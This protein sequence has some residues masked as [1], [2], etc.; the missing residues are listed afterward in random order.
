MTIWFLSDG[1]LGLPIAGKVA[2]ITAIALVILLITLLDIRIGKRHEASRSP[3]EYLAEN[4][5]DDSGS[6]PNRG[7]VP[8]RRKG[9]VVW[10]YALGD[11][12][13]DWRQKRIRQHSQHQR[14]T[15]DQSPLEASTN[16]TR[17]ILPFPRWHIST[18]V[19]RLHRRVNQ[20]GKEP[21]TRFFST[22]VEVYFP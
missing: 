22:L 8:Q 16:P 12:L 14:D 13:S 9:S 6:R 2:A 11:A 20:S 1:F 18:I 15:Y 3:T 7:N 19:K 10:Q 21:A 4:R 17:V 5:P